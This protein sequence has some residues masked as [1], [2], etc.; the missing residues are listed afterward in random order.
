MP[1]SGTYVFTVTRDDLIRQAMMNM[2]KLGATGYIAPQDTLDISRVLNMIVKQW[3][4]TQD[5]APGLKAWT[6]Y[7]ADLF[8]SSTRYRYLLGPTGDNWAAGVNVAQPNGVNYG[9]DQLFANAITGATTLNV[10]VGSTS[11]Y[12][13]GDFLVVQLTNGDIYSTTITTVNTGPGTLTIP[14]PGLPSAAAANNYLWN[15]TTKGQRPLEIQ[16]CVLRDTNSNDTPIDIM[17]L[18]TYEQLPSKTMPTYTSDPTSIYYE[19]SLAN[20]QLFLDVG[21][22]QD[23][24]KILHFVCLRPIQDF[25]NP[26][27]NPDYS[28]EWFL[29][30]S[31]ELT[32][33]ICPMY[34]AV[35][36]DEMGS[37]YRDAMAIA[38]NT[39]PENT[40]IYFMC[41]GDQP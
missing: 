4:G 15:Y 1:S 40:Q 9:T 6:R 16:T 35:W 20:G 38:K 3:M 34:N 21:G 12:T 14:A 8:L 31:W 37:N 5:F 17:T 19:P 33:Q 7:R 11:N 2:G 22:A 36:T 10:G 26:L 28:A 25:N 24:T 39:N 29:P 13:A 23:V 18:Q 27:D 30:L 32:K 41:D